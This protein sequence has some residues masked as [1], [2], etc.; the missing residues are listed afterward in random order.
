M[1]TH[2]LVELFRR[3]RQ[4]LDDLELGQRLTAGAIIAGGGARHPD[5]LAAARRGLRL[6][7]RL[8]LPTADIGVSPLTDP[9]LTGLVGVVLAQARHWPPSA[10]PADAPDASVEEA[11]D[12]SPDAYAEAT[13]PGVWPTL[14]R[15]LR[16]FVPIGDSE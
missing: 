16:E 14:S 8:G 7:V 9:A 1:A 12:A 5:L 3:I 15:W 10:D 2:P 6:P 4:R 11:D 13:R